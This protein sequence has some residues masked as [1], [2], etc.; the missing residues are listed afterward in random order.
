M[1]KRNVKSDELPRYSYLPSRED[2]GFVIRDKN[3]QATC[4]ESTAADAD[5]YKL[6][7]RDIELKQIS[8]VGEGIRTEATGLT[9]VL[10]ATDQL[11][12]NP[13]A[14]AAFTAAA[15]KWEALIQSPITVI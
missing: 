14:K 13:T 2:A 11:N 5:L 4:S 3:D 15:A 10:R 6:Q 8:H 12:A 1:H 7:E 9:I